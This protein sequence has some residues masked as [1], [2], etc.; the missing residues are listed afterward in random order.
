MP[1][2]KRSP[3]VSVQNYP[4]E[5]LLVVRAVA[6]AYGVHITKLL[7]T[8]KYTEVVTA[9]WALVWICK[10]RLS[11]S[12]SH[13]GRLI[14]RNHATVINAVRRVEERLDSPDF[15][16]RLETATALLELPTQ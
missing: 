2:T 4:T 7:G 14:R 15:K 11:Y 1:N 13:I 5:F 9:R 16:R 10:T 3:A 12:L 6:E 8:C